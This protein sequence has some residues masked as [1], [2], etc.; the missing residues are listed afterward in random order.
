MVTVLSFPV[1]WMGPLLP[2]HVKE[3]LSRVIAPPSGARPIQNPV[4]LL[5]HAM[6]PPS[7]EVLLQIFKMGKEQGEQF[8]KE[9]M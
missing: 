2:S 6:V 9:K 5:K 8:V 3:D 1:S 4:M 7:D